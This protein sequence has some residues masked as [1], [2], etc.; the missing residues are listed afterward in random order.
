[1]TIIWRMKLRW[2]F[3]ETLRVEIVDSKRD[4]RRLTVHKE[5]TSRL[6]DTCGGAAQLKDGVVTAWVERVALTKPPEGQPHASPQPVSFQRSHGVFRAGGPK[7][8][9]G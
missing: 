9:D 7:A 2:L 1:M 8:T 5:R 4:I 3:T 6:E